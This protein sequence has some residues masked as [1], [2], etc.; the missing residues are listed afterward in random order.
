MKILCFDPSGNYGKEGMG[1]TGWATFLDGDLIEFGD[2][3][4]SDWANQETYWL[5]HGALINQK[6]PELVVCESYNLFGNK[7][8]AQSGSALETPQLIGFMRMVC[9]TNG[10][11][12]V[13]QNPDQKT[14]VND[15][16]LT[17]AGYLEK[18]GNRYYCKG[19][20]T[21]LH[22]RDAIR[23]GI[24]YYRFGKGKVKK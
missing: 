16:R 2:I 10:I 17:R 19:L 15:E 21:N 9:W 11:A 13:Y 3:K 24:Y 4:A 8:K 14:P 22:Q 6:K 20:L 12:W 23:H 1:T 7:A 18:R 5:Q